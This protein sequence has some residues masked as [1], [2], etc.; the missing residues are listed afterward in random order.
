D[1]MSEVCRQLDG[2]P[3]GIELAAARMRVLSPRA[4]LGR[5]DRRLSL[6]TGG[7]RER[8][9]RQQTLRATIQWSYDLLSH[10]ERSLL[11]RLSVFI[12]GC[13]LDAAEAVCNPGGGLGGGTLGGL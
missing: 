13:R 3:L 6:L 9:P 10:E 2:L 12:G 11:S 4:L 1:A 8:D 7:G 5:L